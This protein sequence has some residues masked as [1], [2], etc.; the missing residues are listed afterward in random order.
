MKSLLEKFKQLPL[1]EM[2]EASKCENVEAYF[3]KKKIEK[4]YKQL[5]K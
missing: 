2:V 3:L 1:K 4:K 5:K